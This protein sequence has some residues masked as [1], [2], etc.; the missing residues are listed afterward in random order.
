MADVR[1]L[2]IKKINAAKDFVNLAANN[3]PD[4]RKKVILDIAERAI[5]N[6]KNI[7]PEC[8]TSKKDRESD[9][10][11]A[12][13]KFIIDLE[14]DIRSSDH[15]LIERNVNDVISA[16]N[17]SITPVIVEEVVEYN[18]VEDSYTKYSSF[19]TKY[20]DDDSDEI[21]NI[22]DLI[23]KLKE[24]EILKAK[25]IA[26][27]A[28]YDINIKEKER[29]M[30]LLVKKREE[31]I[32][33]DKK[34]KTLKEEIVKLEEEE[35]KRKEEERKK[36]EEEERKKL[37][38]EERKRKEEE[39]KRL[40]EARKKGE[41]ENERKKIEEETRKREDEKK[42][43]EDEKKRLEDEKKRLEDEKKR[44]AKEDEKKR[45]EDEKKRLE[46]EK[47]RL[48]DEKK[49]KAKEKKKISQLS[50]EELNDKMLELI[51]FNKYIDT[52]YDN[53]VPIVVLE[54]LFNKFK[55]KRITE[56]I[57]G[58]DSSNYLVRNIEDAI[59]GIEKKIE[60][61]IRTGEKEKIKTIYNNIL[62]YS[63]I[64]P[65]NKD[66][67]IK[68]GL[69]MIPLIIH[70]PEYVE[71][72]KT[73]I[74]DNLSSDITNIIVLLWKL[75]NKLE[76]NSKWAVD[77]DYNIDNYIEELTAYITQIMDDMNSSD[78]DTKKE[79]HKS[80]KLD[81]KKIDHK[82][83]NDEELMKK[84]IEVSK[85]FTYT[86][87]LFD[88][89]A[90]AANLDKIINEYISHVEKYINGQD[91]T[92]EVVVQI[93][94]GIQMIKSQ[95]VSFKDEEIN[96]VDKNMKGINDLVDKKI[97][98]TSKD[99]LLQH[100]LYLIPLTDTYPEIKEIKHKIDPHLDDGYFKELIPEFK[101]KSDLMKVPFIDNTGKEYLIDNPY[102]DSIST[103]DV[104][105][106]SYI[107]N[108]I[109]NIND[110]IV[111]NTPVRIIRGI[112]NNRKSDIKKNIDSLTDNE[113]KSYYLTEFKYIESQIND[114]KKGQDD[115]I[116]SKISEIDRLLNE[117]DIN[118]NLK[119]FKIKYGSIL[120]YL[121]AYDKEH[122]I[123]RRYNK[124]WNNHAYDEKNGVDN[125]L[126]IMLKNKDYMDE[127]DKKYGNDT[128]TYQNNSEFDNEVKIYDSKASLDSK[129]GG[130]ELLTKRG[131]LETF[132]IH[133]QNIISEFNRFRAEINDLRDKINNYEDMKTK[134]SKLANEIDILVDKF[135]EVI[136]NSDYKK[137][138]NI[139][140][141]LLEGIASLKLEDKKEAEDLENDE[142]A[143]ARLEKELYDEISKKGG[144]EFK[145]SNIL[146][147]KKKAL[148]EKIN[149]TK[150]NLNAYKKVIVK[151]GGLIN[152]RIIEVSKKDA[153]IPTAAYIAG[154]AA[155]LTGWPCSV[156]IV[157]LILMIFFFV[158]KIY[159]RYYDNED[160]NPVEYYNDVIYVDYDTRIA[161]NFYDGYGNP[162]IDENVRQ[163]A[164]KDIY[165]IN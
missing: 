152:K 83:L 132:K 141:M 88:L 110:L 17:S 84:A 75:I 121:Q 7:V 42:R 9:G 138:K 34:I 23:N 25:F 123:I 142:E 79:D 78:A 72:I 95:K 98:N 134:I 106:D 125:L 122:D 148:E 111:E 93:N 69:K 68:E 89:G 143:L 159:E 56:P 108:F 53:N 64:I 36:L 60:Y 86:N 100:L 52:L 126:D 127:L 102:R 74:V 30:E 6:I 49:R 13:G 40:E 91:M 150:L 124:H 94:Q 104:K 90:P 37:E 50:I 58:T 96:K 154:G 155:F 22:K 120:K 81:D 145:S 31:I 101:K 38:E 26:D 14:N 162:Y 8:R 65:L 48:E 10:N 117:N 99:V 105:S 44:K 28:D 47:K 128:S 136:N 15:D 118:K 18:K 24:F 107:D 135:N 57:S 55:N 160:T 153:E 3:I 163:I 80:K 20:S 54:K 41:E 147:D 12:D 140:E 116:K 76:D 59:S 109:A 131:A 151:L 21:K 82:S 32:S 97:V 144:F 112:I 70:Y 35:R 46:D 73:Q 62:K 158:S 85:F 119:S 61:K 115:M 5:E 77:A 39:K 103:S 146:L 29:I 4:D 51:S 130:N 113:K 139:N 66:E 129:T 43:L 67:L 114:T 16:L 27:E 157:L 149:N 137:Y 92:N 133:K 33:L 71:T 11:I 164:E 1:D 156:L 19:D 161:T 87:E 63:T 165:G 2:A 45:L